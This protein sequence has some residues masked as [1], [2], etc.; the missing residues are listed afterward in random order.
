MIILGVILL[1]LGLLLGISLLVWIGIILAV[2]GLVLA[3]AGGFG[4]Y[5]VGGRR[6]WY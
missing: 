2:V 4:G 3:L 1:V 5:S 6:H